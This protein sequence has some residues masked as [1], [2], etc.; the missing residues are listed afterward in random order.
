MKTTLT[1][2]KTRLK[3]K[4]EKDSRISDVYCK[5]VIGYVDEII[6]DILSREKK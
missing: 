2:L 1:E 5:I 3:K 6:N 4:I